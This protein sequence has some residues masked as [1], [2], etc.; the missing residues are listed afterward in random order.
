VVSIIFMLRKVMGWG[1]HRMAREMKARGIASVTGRTVY[2]VLA[3][4]GLPIQGYALKGRSEGIAYRRYEKRLPNQQWHIDLKHA[5]LSDGTKGYICAL[6]DDYSRYG[7]AV[8][9]GVAA[10]SGWVKQVVQAAIGRDHPTRWSATTV[11]SSSRYGKRAG[12]R[13]GDCWRGWG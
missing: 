10:T 2:Q 11:G 8:V 3:R 1:G 4:L 5:P 9:A 13:L 7:V 12:R 6:V